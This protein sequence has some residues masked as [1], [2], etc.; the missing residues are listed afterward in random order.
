MNVLM[1]EAM[2]VVT[3]ASTLL[4]HSIVNATVAS[5]Y[6]MMG[7]LVMVKCIS[8]LFCFIL[9]KHNNCTPLKYAGSGD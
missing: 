8:L 9:M 5:S 3:G 1:K 6:K 2:I 7:T 4:D